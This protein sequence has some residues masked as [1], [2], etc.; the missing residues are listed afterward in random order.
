M[1]LGLALLKSRSLF[2]Q[3]YWYWIGI[4]ALIGYTVLFNILFTLFLSKLNRESTV[5]IIFPTF[6]LKKQLTALQDTN[7]LHS[8]SVIFKYAEALGKRQAI[9]SKEELDDR[10]K[11]RK[12]E[13]VVI[14]LR[15]FLQYSGSFASKNPWFCVIAML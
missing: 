14:Q 12:G 1:S 3:S 7:F 6:A 9:V 15:D 13:P 11:M 8:Y 2:P 4:G 5:L 10:E